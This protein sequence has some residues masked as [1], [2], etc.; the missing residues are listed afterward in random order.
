[1]LSCAGTISFTLSLCPSVSIYFLT[2]TD[3]TFPTDK[4]RIAEDILVENKA[5][6][7]F[8]IFSGILH[9]FACRFDPSTP[10]IR[11]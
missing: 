6:Y 11:A 5:Q 4:R 1:M 2:E 7:F 8:Q 10:D 9:G 3:H